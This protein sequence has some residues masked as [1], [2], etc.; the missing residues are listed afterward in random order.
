MQR[1]YTW[2]FLQGRS[3]INSMHA[4]SI[5]PLIALPCFYLLNC[6]RLSQ[7]ILIPHW[8]FVTYATRSINIGTFKM[9]KQGFEIFKP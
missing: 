7:I 3:L 5:T 4:P 8:F 6:K 9:L 1:I 2:G